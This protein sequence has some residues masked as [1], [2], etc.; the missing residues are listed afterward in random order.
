MENSQQLGAI[1]QELCA[2]CGSPSKYRCP[3][4]SV[5]SCS[6]Q[7]VNAHKEENSCNGV[8]D[9]TTFI[10]VEEYREKDFQ[11]DYHFLEEVTR[12]IDNAHRAKKNHGCLNYLPINLFRMQRSAR[13]RGT[14]LRILPCVFSKRKKSTTYY[15]YH[16]R[17]IFWAI[18]WKFP[19]ID[20]EHFDER[21][22]E[23]ELLGKC[24]DKFLLPQGSADEDDKFCLLSI[25]GS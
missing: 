16:D 5:L 23:E 20:L 9:E 7:C 22:D 3:K 24:L 10:P 12:K 19:Q 14:N 21:V 25:N 11:S 15:R 17:K 18:E 6:L 2:T 1:F 13:M 8:R 4:C